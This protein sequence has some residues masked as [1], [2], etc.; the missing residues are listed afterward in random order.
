M[1]QF[2]IY[3][4]DIAVILLAVCVLLLERKKKNK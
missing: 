4:L 2:Q 1:L 3:G